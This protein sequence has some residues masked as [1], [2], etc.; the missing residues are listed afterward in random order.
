MS[1]VSSGAQRLNVPQ[2]VHIQYVLADW[3]LRTPD[4]PALLASGRLP[5]TY[6]RLH[7]HIDEVVQR[8]RTLGVGCEDRVALAMPTGSE[9][10]VAFLA[11]AVG[12]VC[13]AP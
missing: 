3:A 6:G 9:M 10:A 13:V 7:R 11:V 2:H 5:L 12:A 1:H 8:L 4:A